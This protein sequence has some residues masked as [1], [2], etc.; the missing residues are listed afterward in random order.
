MLL[1]EGIQESRR[2]VWALPRASR[3][4][5]PLLPVLLACGRDPVAVAAR[6]QLPHRQQRLLRNLVSFRQALTRLDVSLTR[7]WSAADWTGWLEQHPDPDQVVA[8]ALVCGEQ[9]RRPLLQWWL[10]WR[11]VQP[12]LTA[13]DLI[14]SGLAPGPQIGVRLRQLRA[15]RLSELDGLR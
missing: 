7:S 4:G 11:H 2:W 3:L 6:L 9:P 8:M 5:L 10:Q 13:H 1:G 12:E 15:Q 14:A